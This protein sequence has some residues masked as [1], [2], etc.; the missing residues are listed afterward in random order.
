MKNDSEPLQHY[1]ATRAEEAFAAVVQR[2]LPLVYGAALRRVGGDA[3]RAQDVAQ[4]VFTTVARNAAALAHHPD[5]TGWLFTTTRNL[6]AK[7]LRGERR[8]Q[9]REHAAV[10]AE[11][12]VS[13][14][15]SP[16]SRACLHGVLDD[17]LMDLRPADRQIIL[18][19]FHRGLR[20]ADIGAQ[21]ATSENAVQKRLTRA[22]DHLRETLARRG[23][24]STASALALAFEQ[25][26][27]IAVPAGVAAAVTT[28]G[29]AGLS[30]G[31]LVGVTSLMVVSK[32]QVGLAAAVVAA[33]STG[34]VWEM[35]QN[36]EIRAELRQHTAAT[37]AR[38]AELS[39]SRAALAQRAAAAEADAVELE[40]ALR[41]ARSASSPPQ[42]RTL[43][44]SGDRAKAAMT[45]AH[46]LT[47]AG[48]FQEALDVYLQC[49]RDV[50]GRNTLPNQQIVMSQIK[51]LGETY[52]PAIVAL[53]DLRDSARQRFEAGETSRDVVSEI[54]FL[55][56]RLDEGHA[57]IALYD[58]LPAGDPGRQSLALIGRRAFVDA[59]RYADALVGTPFGS[60]VRELEM[61]IRS[62]ARLTGMSLVTHRDYVI[63]G[64]L[65]HIEVLLGSGK[66][67][68]AAELTQKL[69][70]FDGSDATR[71]ALQHHVD[72]AR[73]AN[74]Q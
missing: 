11:A 5:F 23:I 9:R 41:A 31:G 13:D 66:R 67:E 49:Y 48:K 8:R 10:E 4:L 19:R 55:N 30:G 50:A 37:A 28:A 65:S 1:A 54:G 24:T 25:Q 12:L 38:I 69:L 62:A 20:L 51:Q 73:P 40:Q 64:T 58:R 14:D 27:A 33:S 21:L 15:D 3:H 17:A 6:A 43:S 63:Q 72:R 57:T 32:F 59:K 26:G 34:L 36:S 7:T 45:R 44:D 52:P 60:M 56:E 68:E 71:A 46:E 61:G 35:H 39:D 29:L 42:P 22:L 16:D 70:A 47:R 74:V 53:R 18:L 2:H